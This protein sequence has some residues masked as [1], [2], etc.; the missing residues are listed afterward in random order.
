[1]TWTKHVKNKFYMI[2]D[3][4]VGLRTKQWKK[5]RVGAHYL[6]RNTS[7]VG[8]HVGALGWN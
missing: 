5:K 2:K 8:G 6:I 4:K 1:M 7:R 3:S